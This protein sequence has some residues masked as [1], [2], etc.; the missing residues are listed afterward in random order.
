MCRIAVVQAAM[1]DLF[2]KIVAVRPDFGVRKSAPVDL[3][4]DRKLRDPANGLNPFGRSMMSDGKSG[5]EDLQGILA[6]Q[7]GKMNALRGDVE[8]S[9]L[10]RR[11]FEH[12]IQKGGPMNARSYVKLIG[13]DGRDKTG[14]LSLSNPYQVD[15]SGH[16]IIWESD[17]I[18]DKFDYVRLM[19]FYDKTHLAPLCEAEGVNDCPFFLRRAPEKVLKPRR[20]AGQSHEL[21]IH[22]NYKWSGIYLNNVVRKIA[23]RC[24]FDNADSFTMRSLRRTNLTAMTAGGCSR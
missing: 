3:D 21:Y 7:I 20:Q 18:E 4:C 14:K 2:Q 16:L 12:G 23:Q 10:R 8:P 15:T 6:V 17:F 9:G 24:Q 22:R 13:L 11:S 19:Q 5:V 1:K